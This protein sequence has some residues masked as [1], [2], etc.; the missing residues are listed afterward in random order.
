MINLDEPYRAHVEVFAGCQEYAAEAGWACVIHPFADRA[1]KQGNQNP[2][3]GILARA[4]LPLVKEARRARVPVVNVM[5]N[6]PD[7]EI[8]SVFPDCAAAGALA[9]EHLLGRGFRNLGFLG[10]SRNVFSRL[11]REGFHAVLKREGYPCTDH[12]FGWSRHTANAAGWETFIAGLENWIDGWS[13]P[14]GIYCTEDL[15]CRY[16]IDVCR[17]K[18]LQVPRD[19][20]M[21]GSHDDIVL[22]SSPPPTLTS[23][24]HNYRQIG[25]QAAALLNRLM[26]GARP[27]K[28]PELVPPAELIPRQSTDSYA[29]DDAVVSRALRFMAENSHKSIQVNN[30]AVA[31]STTR[32][33]LER[34]FRETLDRSIAE[35]IVRLRLERAK[36]K[37]VE[38]DEA[39]SL[40]AA[41]SGFSN[42]DHFY[43]VFVR[44]EG[45]SPTK[46]RQKRHS[47][48]S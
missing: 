27:P 28:E 18:G 19:V 9:A 12:S 45:I 23:I 2:Y 35:E 47:P 21:V 1:L 39:L 37:L 33:S 5:V 31:V 46:Y 16:L 26:N 20:A 8:P 40:V 36:R 42:A 4:T 25:Y 13:M 7:S 48:A 34:R 29:V 14:M 17:T 3:D 32:R 22:C 15:P 41:A 6:S 43:K 10:Y 11:Q 30:V 24:N 44:I 38:T